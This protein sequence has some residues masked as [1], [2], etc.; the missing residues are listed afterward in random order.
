MIRLFI[1]GVIA[2]LGLIATILLLLLIFAAIRWA[3]RFFSSSQGFVN[4]QHQVWKDRQVKKKAEEKSEEEAKEDTP[5]FLRQASQRL[6]S[7][8]KNATQLT[9]KWRLLLSPVIKASHEM[10]QRGIAKPEQ[11]Q[12]T[13]S[14]FTVTIKALEGFTET[15]VDMK[16]VMQDKEN[17][18]A[19]QSIAIFMDDIHKYRARFESKKRFDFQ[20]MME[21]IKQR[22]GK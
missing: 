2:I 12:L 18:K 14:F 16:G 1:F 4:S 20:I 7:I 21:V 22:L 15:L 17:E 19:R 11:A 9:E 13:R 6:E 8:D 5:E 10:L 3:K